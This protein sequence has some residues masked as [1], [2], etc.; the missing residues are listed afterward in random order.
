MLIN[1]VIIIALNWLNIFM[2]S[3]FSLSELPD[4]FFGYV[5]SFLAPQLNFYTKLIFIY[6]QA[7]NK[8]ETIFLFKGTLKCFL[9]SSIKVTQ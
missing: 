6:L 5:L 7:S 8:D 1:N 9:H 2:L 4:R 3:I